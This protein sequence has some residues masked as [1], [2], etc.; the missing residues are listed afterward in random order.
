MSKRWLTWALYY[1]AVIAR[2]IIDCQKTLGSHA[3]EHYSAF[4]AWQIGALMAAFVFSVFWSLGVVFVMMSII[5]RLEVWSGK[6]FKFD[7]IRP[8][9]FEFLRR[10]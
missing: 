3:I 2:T 6:L 1:C 10:R 4:G 8:L 5:D 7:S 9:S